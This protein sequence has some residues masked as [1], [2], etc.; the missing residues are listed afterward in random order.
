LP[1]VLG[2]AA[3]V[4]ACLP[5]GEVVN[6]LAVER[7]GHDRYLKG[8]RPG[9]VKVGTVIDRNG[10]RHAGGFFTKRGARKRI[11]REHRE[12]HPIELGCG[13][14]CAVTSGSV[15]SSPSTTG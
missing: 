12:Q 3:A 2:E 15:V 7:E 9:D 11:R 13:R 14:R 4:L 8:E 6:A 10:E 5:V 1:E